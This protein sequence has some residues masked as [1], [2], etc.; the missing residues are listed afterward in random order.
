M[1]YLASRPTTP[2]RPAHGFTLVELLVVIGIIALLISILLPSL[3]RAREAAKQ[4]ACLSNIRNMGTATQMFVN[5]NDGWLF[6]A[7]VNNNPNTVVGD[8]GPGSWQFEYPAWGW[9]YVLSTYMGGN[10]EVFRCPSD[11][12]EVFRGVQ[13]N[14]VAE[15]PGLPGWGLQAGN[16]NVPAEYS[17]NRSLWE[18]DDIPASYRYNASNIPWP[19]GS[20]KLTQIPNATRSILIAEGDPDRFHHFATW[21]PGAI[22]TMHQGAWEIA[23]VGRHVDDRLSYMFYDGH[24]EVLSWEETW[25]PLGD[26][27]NYEATFN[28]TKVVTPTPWRTLYPGSGT[29]WND[30]IPF[31]PDFEFPKSYD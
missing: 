9:D 18:A 30:R 29:T 4:T 16:P 15:D 5:E 26:S 27:F 28:G 6:K 2:A 22:G 1:T 7:W 3:S 19:N 31:D 11:D 8:L 23:S 24:G 25:E 17:S 13:F 14:P 20:Q 10:K 21:E 12:S